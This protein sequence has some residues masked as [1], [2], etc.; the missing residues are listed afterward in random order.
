VRTGRLRV[1][2]DRVFGLADIADA[3]RHAEGGDARGKIV[4]TVP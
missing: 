4:V 2:V 1:P 3:H